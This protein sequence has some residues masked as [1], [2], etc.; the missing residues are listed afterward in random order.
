MGFVHKAWM[1]AAVAAQRG[2]SGLGT[3]WVLCKGVS[4]CGQ[5]TLGTA[6]CKLN[7]K[8]GTLDD[9]GIHGIYCF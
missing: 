3:T 2:Q 6:A 1:T 5:H 8:P 7:I 9:R 4:P